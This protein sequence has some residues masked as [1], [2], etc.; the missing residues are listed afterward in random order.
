LRKYNA[1]ITPVPPITYPINRTLFPTEAD[2]TIA[3]I[4]NVLIPELNAL[5]S[6]AV[7]DM[8]TGIG[9]ASADVIIDADH[10]VHRQTSSGL[11]KK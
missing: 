5:A 6:A 2:A 3:A 7:G 11:L 4:T 8:A 1:A 9:A 10:M